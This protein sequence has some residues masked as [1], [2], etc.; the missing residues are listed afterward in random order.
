[1]LRKALMLVVALG[2]VGTSPPNA[3]ASDIC[4]HYSSSGGG[5]LVA[6]GASLPARNTCQPLAMYEAAAGGLVGAATGS[7]CMDGTGGNTLVYHYTYDG[8][9]GD[10]HESGTCRIQIGTGVLPTSP[11]SGQGSTCRI[12]LGNGVFYHE[13]PDLKAWTCDASQ[14]ALAVPGGG[15]GECLLEKRRTAPT[16]GPHRPGNKPK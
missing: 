15:G 11:D 8:C 4:F 10:Y 16:T 3:T 2:F 1:M 14:L 5:I 12:T 13:D 6:P 7:L 9:S